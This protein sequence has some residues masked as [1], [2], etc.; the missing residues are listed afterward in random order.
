MLEVG[1]NGAGKS[2]FIKIISGAVRPTSGIIV[3]APLRGMVLTGSVDD[4]A[5]EIRDMCIG[6]MDGKVQSLDLFKRQEQHLLM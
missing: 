1:E 3:Y 5:T 2:T 4:T 6:I